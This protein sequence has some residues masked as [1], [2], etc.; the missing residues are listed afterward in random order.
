MDTLIKN[1]RNSS[2]CVDNKIKSFSPSITAIPDNNHI[3]I[4][5]VIEGMSKLVN[6]I[7]NTIDTTL[8]PLDESNKE[9][10]IVSDIN[11]NRFKNHVE[12]SEIS[13]NSNLE[14]LIKKFR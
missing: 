6:R 12:S 10:I 9:Y 14:Q 11:Y 13:D 5:E 8:Y 1:N 3:Y 7:K 2:L 4:Y